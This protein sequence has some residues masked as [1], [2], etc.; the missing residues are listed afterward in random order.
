MPCSSRAAPR[1][2]PACP[3]DPSD[4]HS[5][6]V[7]RTVPLGAPSAVRH[8][9]VYS[10]SR[11]RADAA[12]GGLRHRSCAR[13]SCD[14]EST[15][16]STPR[17][18]SADG[19][20]GDIARRPLAMGDHTFDER[21]SVRPSVRGAH[22]AGPRARA[23]SVRRHDVQAVMTHEHGCCEITVPAMSASGMTAS[24]AQQRMLSAIE[25]YQRTFSWRMSPCRFFPSCSSYAHEAI[26]VHG[27]RRG[28]WL[29]MR[30]LSRC[31]PLGPAGVD[32]VPPPAGSDH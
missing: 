15:P 28:L 22:D 23:T 13:P 12:N 9:V 4:P 7:R 25:W 32:L 24:K 6:T 5:P 31:R 16:A 21:T 3:L 17:D 27:P 29:A 8:V 26:T 19:Q 1:A 10:P 30:R 18:L 14:P 11:L 20:R 2:A